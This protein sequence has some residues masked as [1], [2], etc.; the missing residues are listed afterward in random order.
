MSELLK[1]ILKDWSQWGISRVPIEASQII[2]LPQGLT[3]QGYLLSLPHGQYVLRI[4]A[5]NSQ[6]LDINRDAE[7]CI[8][9]LLESYQ[10][11]PKIYYRAND[12]SYWLREYVEGTVLTPQDLNLDTLRQ[13]AAYLC[14]IHRL[15][16][17]TDL[18]EI[19]IQ[20]KLLHYQQQLNPQAN[21]L[22]N[23]AGS[24][25]AQ[26]GKLALCHMD[27]TPANW[28]LMNNGK[29]MLLDWEYAGLG[30]PLWDIAALLQQA[31]LTGTQE[32]EFLQA[33]GLKQDRHW[34][35]AKQDMHDLEQQ[36][37]QVQGKTPIRFRNNDCVGAVCNRPR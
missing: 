15:A 26:R 22:A 17:P 31:N 5:T 14:R 4:A 24:L 37:Y 2:A 23:S 11:A 29:L 7:Y 32:Q 19:N 28:I 21:R 27:P 1:Y 20:A 8:H 16:T 18:P 36:W 12:N 3:N 25:S 34:Q 30:N 6:A 9:A 13:M 35:Q 10:L 33:I